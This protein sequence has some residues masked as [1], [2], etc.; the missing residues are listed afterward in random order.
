MQSHAP[1]FRSL[2]WVIVAVLSFIAGVAGLPF[3]WFSVLM[4]LLIG[5]ALASVLWRSFFLGGISV[6]D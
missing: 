6:D 4:V 2:W 1:A 3:Q 5:L